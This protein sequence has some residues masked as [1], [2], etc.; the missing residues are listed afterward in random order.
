MAP[1]TVLTTGG[2]FRSGMF[3]LKNGP[4]TGT[5]PMLV[6]P[7][8]LMSEGTRACKTTPAS[9]RPGTGAVP[10][11]DSAFFWTNP[12]ACGLMNTP[13]WTAGSTASK[14]DPRLPPKDRPK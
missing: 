9:G 13:D 4:A 5:P 7:G 6:R 3:S 2:W 14:S 8:E 11:A 1:A 12:P 10:P